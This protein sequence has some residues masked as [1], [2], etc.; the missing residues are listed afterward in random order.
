[1]VLDFVGCSYAA[2]Q[3]VSAGL[4]HS[5]NDYISYVERVSS[6]HPIFCR[7]RNIALLWLRSFNIGFSTCNSHKKSKVKFQ[8]D[9]TAGIFIALL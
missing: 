8:L 6:Y 4:S 7:A 5:T 2:S 9:F 1:M 3:R